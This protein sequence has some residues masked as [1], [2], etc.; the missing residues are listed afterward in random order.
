MSAEVL[1]SFFGFLTACVVSLRYLGG[2]W[3]KQQRELRQLERR[4]Y[5][6]A[7]ENLKKET[8]SL[9]DKLSH[10]AKKIE[11]FEVQVQAVIRKFSDNQEQGQAVLESLRAFVDGT[12]ARFNEN[13]KRLGEVIQRGKEYNSQ[14]IA[15]GRDLTM[16]K[17]K[18]Q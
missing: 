10:H 14:I 2:Y 9:K 8:T 15:L 1:V 3:F 17:G 6:A 16:I 13:E 4:V 11:E 18:K 12:N 5:D 7:I